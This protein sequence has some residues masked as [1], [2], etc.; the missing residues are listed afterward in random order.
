MTKEDKKILL[1]LVTLTEMMVYPTATDSL[2]NFIHGYE[3]GRKKKFNFIPLLQEFIT[4][5]YKIKPTNLGWPQQLTT[6]AEKKGISWMIVF[7]QITLEVIV[8]EC[9]GNLEQPLKRMLVKRITSLIEHIRNPLYDN[10]S[11]NWQGIT[12]TNKKWF[13]QLW[14][15]KELKIIKA[16]TREIKVNNLYANPITKTPSIK[17]LALKNKFILIK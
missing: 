16:I 15:N 9:D 2:V 11:I 7:K 12:A 3:T 6:L 17:L 5:N 8:Q 4:V 10:W 1:Q 13:K 14:N